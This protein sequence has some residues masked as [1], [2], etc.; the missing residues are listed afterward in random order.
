LV[1]ILSLYLKQEGCG[2]ELFPVRQG[3]G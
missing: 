3:A 1:W 2:T